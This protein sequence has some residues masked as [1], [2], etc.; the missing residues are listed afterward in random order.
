MFDD[1]RAAK[2]AV[3][4]EE[5]DDAPPRDESAPAGPVLPSSVT[6]TPVGVLVT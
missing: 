5:P 3:P 4:A 6:I 1:Y 2:H